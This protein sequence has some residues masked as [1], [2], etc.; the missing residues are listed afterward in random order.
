MNVALLV[1]QHFERPYVESQIQM[2]CARYGW[3]LIFDGSGAPLQETRTYPPP[4][5]KAG[6]K[7]GRKRQRRQRQPVGTAVA[8][9]GLYDVPLLPW[10]AAYS[11]TQ[12]VLALIGAYIMFLM[13]QV[14]PEAA[15]LGW[16]DDCTER[17]FHQSTR[18]VEHMLPAAVQTGV[19][20]V[21]RDNFSVE[22]FF[23][24]IDPKHVQWRLED[25]LLRGSFDFVFAVEALSWLPAPLRSG[26]ITQFA[27]ESPLSKVA[28]GRLFSL[29]LGL[30]I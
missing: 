29:H 12:V 23:R 4:A 2:L 9:H 22:G 26:V 27:Q 16:I 15:P 17:T 3:L 5:Q 24:G 1:F 25:Q 30:L 11:E 18:A 7:F 8:C 10:V 21:D 20:V 14:D 19:I 6:M 13:K 28:A